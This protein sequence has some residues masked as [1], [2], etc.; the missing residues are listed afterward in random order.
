MEASALAGSK[1]GDRAPEFTPVTDSGDRVNLSDFK[2]KGVVLYFYPRD[3]TP[4]CRAQAC[5]LGMHM[6]GLR[7]R[8]RR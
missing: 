5:G 8:T 7:R 4:G 3:A 1:I 6:R 2:G